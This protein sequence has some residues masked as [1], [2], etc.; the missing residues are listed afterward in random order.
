[1]TKIKLN[2]SQIQF[3]IKENSYPVDEKNKFLSR[4]I[5][6][7]YKNR[8]K[9]PALALPGGDLGQL[10]LVIACSNDFGLEINYEKVFQSLIKVIGGIKNFSIIL[11]PIMVV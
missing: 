7:R 4:C 5:D 2:P 10:A 11:T 8:S 9:L 1:M 6:G 3:L